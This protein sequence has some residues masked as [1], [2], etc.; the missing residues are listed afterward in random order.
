MQENKTNVKAVVSLVIACLSV[1]CCCI[2]YAGMLLGL[3]AV[4]VGVLALRDNQVEKSDM[5]I[6]GIVVGGV[7]F[8]MGAAVA[9]IYLLI[10]GGIAAGSLSAS[11][12]VMP[13]V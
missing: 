5:A 4:I 9:I 1:V 8:A 7:G 6:A 13:L 3:A 10:Y 2:W 12:A 11:L